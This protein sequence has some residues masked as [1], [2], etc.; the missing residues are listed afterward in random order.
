MAEALGVGWPSAID[1]ELAARL[2]RRLPPARILLLPLWRRRRDVERVADIAYGDAGRRN[3]LDLYRHR[4][5]PP[6]GP[7]LIHLHGGGSSRGR[8][9]R[10][11]LPCSTGWPAKAGSVSAPT[12]ACGPPPSTPTTCSTSRR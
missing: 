4:A 9:H 5:R 11:A 2:R 8:K 6:G 10:Q 7:V 3:L 1:P 12:T